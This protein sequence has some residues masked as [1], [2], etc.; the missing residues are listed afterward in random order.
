[1]SLV[2]ADS[3]YFLAL[4]NPKDAGHEKAVAVSEPSARLVTTQ[5]ILAEVG[6]A[7]SA[8]K[9]RGRFAALIDQLNADASVSVVPASDADFQRGVAMF[10]QR[11]DKDWTLTDCLSFVVM[12]QMGIRQALTADRHFRQ[13][14]FETL[15]AD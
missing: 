15:L 11:P 1:M 2:F 6:D 14:G 10:R 4:L 9:D 7:L 5:W 8:P 13:A 3:Y 12:Q